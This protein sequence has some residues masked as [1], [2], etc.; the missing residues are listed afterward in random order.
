MREVA[1]ALGCSGS[2][3]SASALVSGPATTAEGARP[4]LRL[5]Q[6][7][8]VLSS[9]DKHARVALTYRRRLSRS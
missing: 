4:P 5:R 3:G 8:G 2:V 9:P 7:S 1:L 6:G